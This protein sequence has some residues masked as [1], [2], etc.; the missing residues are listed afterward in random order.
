MYVSATDEAPCWVYLKIDMLASM[1][2]EKERRFSWKKRIT[3]RVRSV[4]VSLFG[5]MEWLASLY[6]P[7]TRELLF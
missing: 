5:T 4:I 6:K 1:N 3:G 2:G 7:R